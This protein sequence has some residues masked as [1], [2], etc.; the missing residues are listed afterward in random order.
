MDETPRRPR[1]TRRMSDRS[2]TKGGERRPETRE[3]RLARALRANLRRRK[4]AAGANAES[5]RQPPEGGEDPS[6]TG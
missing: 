1:Y 3:E 5:A 2:E 4:A 6:E